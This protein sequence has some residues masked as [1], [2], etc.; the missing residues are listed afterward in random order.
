[1]IVAPSTGGVIPS[2]K[3]ALKAVLKN[4][5][6]IFT[7]AYRFNFHIKKGDKFLHE[8]Q[9]DECYLFLSSATS[10]RNEILLNHQL[11]GLGK[12]G[13]INLFIHKN[14]IKTAHAA[15]LQ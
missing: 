11:V 3:E 13:V 10:I 15:K 9:R 12:K 8:I 1:M 2:S 6:L 5:D 4:T 14:T 7:G